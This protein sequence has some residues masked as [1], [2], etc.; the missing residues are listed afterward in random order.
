ML[1]S[2]KRKATNSSLVPRKEHEAEKSGQLDGA[3]HDQDG[4]EKQTHDIS[5]AL[6]MVLESYCIVLCLQE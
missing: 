2:L 4:Y 3:D 6:Q 1:L 5:S